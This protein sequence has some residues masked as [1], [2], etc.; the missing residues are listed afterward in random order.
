MFCDLNQAIVSGEIPEC[1]IVAV[2][3][4]PVRRVESQCYWSIF[5][6]PLVSL[7]DI[8]DYFLEALGLGAVLTFKNPNNKSLRELGKV[9][10]G[11]GHGW[12]LHTLTLTVLFHEVPVAVRNAFAFDRRFH[13]SWVHN[14]QSTEKVTFTATGSLKEW[15]KIGQRATDKSFHKAQRDW[16]LTAYD[17]ITPT[18]PS[19]FQ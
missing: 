3:G 2:G 6:K 18:F 9:C 12:T 14:E 19:Y 15:K 13:L 16:F 8:E 1:A 7:S 10:L 4:F 11:L 5:N 17:L